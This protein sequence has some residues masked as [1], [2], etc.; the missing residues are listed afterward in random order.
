MPAFQLSPGHLYYRGNLGYY[1]EIP[2]DMGG[3]TCKSYSKH[4]KAQI[5]L[6]AVYDF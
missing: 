3:L 5:V 6:Q 1:V 4:K 2:S